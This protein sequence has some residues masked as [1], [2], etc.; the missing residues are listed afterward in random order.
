MKLMPLLVPLFVVTTTGPVVAPLGMKATIL[1]SLQL[2]IPNGAPLSETVLDNCPEPKLVPVIVTEAPNSPDVGFKVVM[3]G[4]GILK[5]ALLLVTP[6]TLTTTTFVPV[7][8]AGTV[9]T[10]LV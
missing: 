9:T 5:F 7:K 6:P 3:V 2:V 8:P 4:A 10:I 1:V